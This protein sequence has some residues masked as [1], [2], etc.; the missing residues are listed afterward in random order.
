MSIAGRMDN[1]E[2]GFL[3]SGMLAVRKKEILPVVI[4]RMDTEDIMLRERASQPVTEGQI[5]HDATY[6]RILKWSRS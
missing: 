4:T 6:T 2:V 3:S 5:V 1:E